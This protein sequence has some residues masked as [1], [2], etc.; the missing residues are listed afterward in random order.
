MAGQM[1]EHGINL[2]LTRDLA[3]KGGA[4]CCFLLLK[5]VRLAAT[6]PPVPINVYKSVTREGKLPRVRGVDV[7]E[8]DYLFRS[9]DGNFT[10]CALLFNFAFV[11]E[12]RNPPS[13]EE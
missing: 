8:F 5:Y 3:S 1:F 11:I 9:Y 4:C 10:C 2:G 13:R 12:T 7:V 6:I